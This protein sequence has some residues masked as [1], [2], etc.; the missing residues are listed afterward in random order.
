MG[1]YELASLDSEPLYRPPS[2]ASKASSQKPLTATPE[3]KRY[4]GGWRTGL[5]ISTSAAAFVTLANVI[6]LGVVGARVNANG[7]ALW[8]GDCK[9]AKEYSLWLHL[10]INALAT[11]LLGA[12]NYTQQVLTGPTRQE[13][14]QAHNKRQWLDIGVS[15]IHNLTKI[16]I[17]RV[18]AWTILALSSLP[19]HLLYNSVVSFETSA[20]YFL[21]YTATPNDL[22]EQTL[23]N[24]TK[25]YKN[26]KSSIG[27][28]DKLPV[29]ECLSTYRRNLLSTR[30]D[31]ILVLDT[32]IPY[33]WNNNSL[34]VEI[35]PLQVQPP[36]KN[37]MCNLDSVSGRAVSLQAWDWECDTAAIKSENW[38]I[39]FDIQLD[40]GLKPLQSV[41]VDHCYSKPTHEHCKVVVNLPLLGGVIACNFVKLIG[42][43]L[44]WLYLEKRPLLTL[45]D[46]VDSFLTNPDPATDKRHLMSKVSGKKLS[47]EPGPRAW[48]PQKRRWATAVSWRRY[49]VTV[50]LCIVTIIAAAILLS[51]GLN[52]L[53]HPSMTALWNRGFGQVNV[54]A[55]INFSVYN[56]NGATKMVVISNLPQLILSLLYTA[57]NGMWTTMLVGAE[58]NSYGMKHK[59]LR[60]TYPVGKQRKTYW[61]SLPLRYGVPLIFGS[62]TLHWLISQSIFFVKV[63]LWRND[64]L[65]VDRYPDET[66]TCGYSPIAIIFSII[67][68]S[69][70]LLATVGGSMRTM[71]P[72]IPSGATCSAVI[73]SA[74]HAPEDDEGAAAEFVRWGV[75][76]GTDHCSMT[77]FAVEDPVTGRW[78]Q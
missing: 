17:K 59:G 66:T 58:W 37:W 16:S 48:L 6:F 39:K 21:V 27:D 46:A 30:G 52:T 14:D 11:V 68:G 18:V 47:W 74:C 33:I 40:A 44:T 65:L 43:A 51:M 49:G 76:P 1:E 23:S 2:I 42:L 45:G 26:L 8:T 10:A 77:S 69:L 15:S 3:K 62:A 13:I 54:D 25:T 38:T 50:F 71:T 67:L 22:K 12:G 32:N 31:V 75:V 60:T 29:D 24:V 61:L 36:S 73:S 7:G 72:V 57:I 63:V 64:K 4:F 9:T 35:N 28:F 55:L 70:I 5:A 34:P 78:Y 53:G 20:N 19:I 56:I 41:R